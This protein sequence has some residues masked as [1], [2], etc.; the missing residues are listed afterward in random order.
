MNGP[1]GSP[2]GNLLVRPPRAAPKRSLVLEK[3]V[4]RAAIAWLRLQRDVHVERINVTAFGP[5]GSRRYRSAQKGSADLHVTVGGRALYVE[6]K[7]PGEKQRPAQRD[8]QAAVEAAGN[9]YIVED[10]LGLE[11]LQAAVKELRACG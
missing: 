9:V 7:R 1:M 2:C 10:S 6:C 8:Y 11:T 3:H 4:L 5:D